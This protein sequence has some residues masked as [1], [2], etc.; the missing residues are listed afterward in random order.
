MWK[1]RARFP[2]RGG[3][4][5]DVGTA[6]HIARDKSGRTISSADCRIASCFADTSSCC[7]RCVALRTHAPPLPSHHYSTRAQC[8]RLQ[9][10]A[11]VQRSARMDCRRDR[12]KHSTTQYCSVLPGCAKCRRAA[13][14]P[15]P[16]TPLGQPRRVVGLQVAPEGGRA[17]HWRSRM[18]DLSTTTS[19]R[20]RC[21]S[22][23][24][25]DGAAW[26]HGTG[27]DDVMRNW[28]TRSRRGGGW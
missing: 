3:T 28:R 17:A 14:C 13:R 20:L 24:C 25:G 11:A 27:H 15:H 1:G 21:N 4:G 18:R 5:I 23:S 19:A 16:A 12:P 8:R 22:A 26:Q 9:I 10:S 2:C 6:Y 7:P